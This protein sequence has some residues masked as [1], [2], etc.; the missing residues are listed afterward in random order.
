MSDRLAE[1]P[2]PISTARSSDA[3][4]GDTDSRDPAQ[5]SADPNRGVEEF[6][7]MEEADLP[8]PADRSLRPRRPGRDPAVAAPAAAPVGRRGQRPRGRGRGAPVRLLGVRSAATTRRLPP[9]RSSARTP[10]TTAGEAE[11]TTEADEW[12]RPDGD[13]VTPDEVAWFDTQN[14][15]VHQ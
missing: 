8:V 14:P 11:R 13:D 10:A 5:A 2:G 9:A 1:E 15:A 6:G 3:P 7:E 4:S 12:H